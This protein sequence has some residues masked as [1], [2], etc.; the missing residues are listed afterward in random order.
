MGGQQRR[1]I[2][3]ADA[4]PDGGGGNQRLAAAHVALQKAV[5][6]G[7]AG[8]IGQ[9]F[10]YGPAL[11][12]G[13]GEGERCPE[14]GRVEPM[15]GRTGGCAAPVLHP[16]NAQ[17][18]HQ[19]LLIDEPPPGCKSLLLCGRA[20][21]GPHGIGLGEQAVFFQHL[22]WQRVGQEFRMGGAAAGYILAIMVLESPSV[23]G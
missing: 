8:Q 18:E 11:G 9:N 12:T 4:G 15:H 2:S 1:L 10:V 13:G 3:A 7:A 19:Q 6:G 14:G 20:V 16:P 21:D 5:H 22:L 17:L 23:W